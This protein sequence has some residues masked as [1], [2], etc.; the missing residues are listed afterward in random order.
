MNVRNNFLRLDLWLLFCILGL[1]FLG[2]IT[3]FSISPQ[4]F[5]QQ[6]TWTIFGFLTAC[7]F[8]V[9]D[10]RPI[11]E[12]R[13]FYPSFYFF[14]VFLL[15]LTFLFAPTIRATRSWLVI[16]PMQ[17]QTA[18]FAKLALIVMLSYFFAK[19]H[20]GIA[21]LRNIFVS[22]F[23]F[24][25]PAGFIFLQP[26]MGSI[27]ILFFIWLGYLIVSG[28]RIRHLFFGGLVAIVLMF[29]LWSG[30]LKNYQKERIKGLFDQNYDPLGVNYNT[31]QAKIA[32]GSAGLLGKG[33]FSGT[34]VQLGFL[35]EANADFIFAGFVESWGFFGALFMLGLYFLMVL[36]MT[37]LGGDVEKNFIKLLILGFIIMILAHIFFN[38]GSAL[39]ILPVIGV[40]LSFVSYG[41]SHILILWTLY[42]IIQGLIVRE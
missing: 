24:L 5:Q 33:L 2:L 37:K 41:G 3:I 40:P 25:I 4:L 31:N 30:V 39:A 1:S 15:V 8:I 14:G 12:Y 34:Q 20:V 21:L 36:R 26:D 29:A 11:L 27:L 13:W 9:L 32:V 42:G 22:F 17:F 38:I 16:G 7:F 19:R 6:L 23:Y 35:P 10:I 18:E 28:L